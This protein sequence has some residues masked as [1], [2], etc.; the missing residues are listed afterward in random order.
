MC[1]IFSYRN[2]QKLGLHKNFLLLEIESE[3]CVI[4]MVLL[5]TLEASMSLKSYS[6]T[7]L[8]PS[9]L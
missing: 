8:S 3:S 9:L 1:L 5:D 6:V 2:E 7:E 4:G